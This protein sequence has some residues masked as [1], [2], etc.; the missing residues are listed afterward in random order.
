MS[1]SY[2]KHDNGKWEYRIKFKDPFTQKLKEKSKRG[3]NSKPEARYKAQEVEKKLLEGY[4]T[5]NIDVSLEH[6]LREW[7]YLYKK[8]SVRKNTYIM[9]ERNVE[10]HILLYF[11]N[12][13]LKDIKPMMYQKFLKELIEKGYARRTVEI[14]HTTM[15]NAL[16]FAVKPLQKIKSNPC[17]GVK[18][19]QQKNN[20]ESKDLKYM[21]SED[22]PKFLNACL[23]D[24]YIYWIFFK[25]LLET[26]MRK[27]EACALQWSDIDLK[28]GTIYINKTLD[29]SA[30]NEEELFGDTKTFSST[31]TITI[32]KN[33]IYNLQNHLKWQNDNKLHVNQLYKHHIN[34]VFSRI[35]GNFL[36][37]STLF[38]SFNRILEKA[39]I[40]KLKIHHL[41]HTH[42]VILLES[43][44]TMKYVQERLG[45]K[46][47]QIT[48]DVYAHISKKLEEDTLH[49]YEEY[50]NKIMKE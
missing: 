8:D 5:D 36:P 38:N 44:A 28:A 22:I 40:K 26:G 2:R 13:N 11:K 21:M 4:E 6:Y 25:T 49:Q 10:K 29:Q 48:S 43:K 17:E 23:E 3:F 45:H 16:K 9:H 27:G 12:I 42:A 46:N 47:I 31:R 30:E 34:L 33:L 14:I 37:K 50:M 15:N 32:G 19:P 20:K 39:G 24:N 18:I 41:R 1:I 7:L 35:D